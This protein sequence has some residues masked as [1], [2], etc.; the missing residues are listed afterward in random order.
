MTRDR[1]IRRV[2]KPVVFVLCLGPLGWF[3]WLAVSGGLG[4]NPIEAT[5]RYFGDWGLRFLLIALA[6]TPLREVTGWNVLGRFRRML[7]L[8]AFFYV[9]LHLASYIGLDLFFDWR[10]L[11]ADVLKRRYITIGMIGFLL[12]VPLAATSTKGWIRRLGGRRW[13]K[14]HRAVYAAGVL[15]VLHFFLMIK[16]GYQEPAVYAA[17][18]AAL[19]GWRIVS[20][21]RRRMAPRRTLSANG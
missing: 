3:G 4:V 6:V 16:A 21:L 2:A 13:R 14:L 11:W 10:A 7:G 9:F 1:W 20:H 17:I 8:Y 12:L 19:L 15:G 5:N 18:L